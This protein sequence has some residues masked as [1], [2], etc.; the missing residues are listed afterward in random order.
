MKTTGVDRKEVDSSIYRKPMCDQAPKGNQK[1]INRLAS[2]L[3]ISVTAVQ[4]QDADW[5][6]QANI[7]ESGQDGNRVWV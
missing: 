6:Q 3:R 1:L 4:T 5:Q 7:V 2:P